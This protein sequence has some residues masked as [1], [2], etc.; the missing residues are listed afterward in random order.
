MGLVRDSWDLYLE[1][2]TSDYIDIQGGTT[3]EGI[4]AGVMA[5]TVLMA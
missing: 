4:H 3:K 5:G 2:L 1:A